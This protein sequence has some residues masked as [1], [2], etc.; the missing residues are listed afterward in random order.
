MKLKVFK[1]KYSKKASKKPI[2]NKRI[3]DYQWITSVTIMAFFISLAFSFLAE[4]TIPNVSIILAIIIILAFIGFN[5]IFD[6]IGI[7]ITVADI[8]TF[9]S[10]ATKKVKGAKIA[11]RLI[12]NNEKASS[13]CND[14][15]GDICGIISGSAGVA[16]TSM[17]ADKS[18]INILFIGLL[19]TAIIAALTIGG[20]AI[21]KATA[22]NKSTL[23]LYEFS[24]II[25]WLSRK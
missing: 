20:K 13:F 15:I 4:V 7:A 19:I 5:I 21:G 1:E 3:V 17:I 22:I 8:K 18:D 16:L 11:V 14:V 12:K 10:M 9:N 6:M 24:K 25:A 23:I 2:K